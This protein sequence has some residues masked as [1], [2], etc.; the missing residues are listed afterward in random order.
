MRAG[1]RRLANAIYLQVARLETG[2]NHS[3]QAQGETYANMRVA[4]R[5]SEPESI[6]ATAIFRIYLQSRE[7][8]SA[9]ATLIVGAEAFVIG[10]ESRV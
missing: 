8:R 6:R 3:L 7:G 1:D 4:V 2:I 10:L 5:E 9:A